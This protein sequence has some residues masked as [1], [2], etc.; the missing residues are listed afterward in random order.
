MELVEAIKSKLV[1]ERSTAM[2]DSGGNVKAT[3]MAN[4]TGQGVQTLTSEYEIML[5]DL[6]QCPLYVS[7]RQ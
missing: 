4:K 6:V 3:I 7:A 2:M 1:D 5:G